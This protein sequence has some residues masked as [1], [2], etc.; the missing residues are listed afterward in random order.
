MTRLQSIEA[1]LIAINETV[2]QEL[3]DAYLTLRNKNYL[4]FAR[5]GSQAGK[6]KTTKGTPD[7]FF[8][9]PNGRY[10]FVEYSTNITAGVE[11]LADDIKKCIDP[12]KTGVPI[13]EIEEI[14]IC[15]NF[16]LKSDEIASLRAIL[17]RTSIIL[18]ICTLDELAIELHL[19]HR[20]LVH[21]YLGLPLDTGQIISLDNF[22]KE[23]ER[24]AHG[25]A[26]PI[27]NTFVHRQDELANLKSLIDNHDFIIVTGSAGV[28]KTKLC[29][30]TI[31]QYLKENTSFHAF[32]ISDKGHLLLDDLYTYLSEDQDCILF[33]DDANRIDRFN[34]ITGFY[35]GS[36]K[37]KLKIIVTVRDYA[38]ERIE[39]LCQGFR[40]ASIPVMKLTDEQIRD[41]IKA[42]PFKI[43]NPDYQKEIIRIADGNPRL[44]IMASLL[45]RK[46]EKLEALNDVGE[47]FDLY[48]STFVQDKGEFSNKLN[49]KVLGLIAFFYAVPFKDQEF[50]EPVLKSF[51]ITYSQFIDTIDELEKLEL[52]DIQFEHVKISEQNLATFFFYKAFISD[53][54]LAFDTLL[55]TQFSTN[56][57]RFE[58]TVIPANNNFGYEKVMQ[59]L[60]P[61]LQK[62]LYSINNDHKSTFQFLQSFWFYLQDETLEYI[63]N[64]IAKLPDD[65]STE[66]LYNPDQ[67]NLY[68]ENDEVIELLSEF[69][70]FPTNKLKDA[71]ELCFEYVRKNKRIFQNL[72]QKIKESLKFDYK[73]EQSSY[74]RQDSLYDLLI[75]HLK[76][77]DQIYVRSFFELSKSFL[78]F[79][80]QHTKAARGHSISIYQYPLKND[81]GIK[82]FRAR[83][84]TTLDEQFQKYYDASF[85]LLVSYGKRSPDVIDELM[86][87][88][89]ILLIP[90][91]SQHLSPENFD[92]CVYVQSQI[93]WFR[94]HGLDNAKFDEILVRFRNKEYETYLK[95]DWDRYRDKEMFEFDD[96]KQYD[97]LKEAEVRGNFKFATEDDIKNFYE[98]FLKIKNKAN[99][100]W[101]YTNVLD[102]IIDETF[103]SDFVLGVK[104]LEVI[105]KTGNVIN[106]VPFRLFFN[107]VKTGEQLSQIVQLIN[108]HNFDAKW[109]WELSLYNT[110]D[111]N[112]LHHVKEE[113]IISTIDGITGYTTLD[114]N[115]LSK[116]LPLYPYLIS[117]IWALIYKKNQAET[118][119]I[120]IWDDV[121]ERDLNAWSISDQ[122][123]EDMYIQQFN[124]EEHYDFDSQSL[125]KLVIKNPQ[126][127]KTYINE[128][129][130]KLRR[131]SA[132]DHLRLGFIWS[133]NNIEP[134]IEELF[135][136]VIDDDN[137]GM[138]NHF[139][140]SFFNGIDNDVQLKANKFLIDYLVKNSTDAQRVDMVVNI[141]RNSQKELF[142][143][144]LL[145]FLE[146]NPDLEVFKSVWWRGNGGVYSGEVNMGDEEAAD[147]KRI[148]NTVEK[149]S[150]GIKL[151]PIKKYLNDMIDASIK[152]GD[153]ERKR[154]FLG[155]D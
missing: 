136:T 70:R 63:Y 114:L 149:S 97:K 89:V 105:I 77:D 79:K 137:F 30:E 103:H 72:V 22:V 9:L 59:K 21:Q 151:I 144:I 61:H 124:E 147:W 16:K 43:L 10:L 39:L 51:D 127:I 31:N 2:F 143:D 78:Q 71:L 84:W 109:Q 15:I 150:S 52:V 5:S 104:F 35:R 28:G 88:D 85:Q 117:K 75:K 14:I 95:L 119:K 32:C 154:K 120:K 129:F 107:H 53:D 146:V 20:D 101:N 57:K 138:S 145:K 92:H 102:M 100:P 80:F 155:Y 122:M 99:N 125:K 126:F 135:E 7:T 17:N 108:G 86:A 24:A 55:A 140:N 37:G 42:E 93:L 50:I 44:A 153:W 6:Q 4:A 67:N 34:Q 131:T 47:L 23:Y 12:K 69:W 76:D 81:V 36:R 141:A 66:Y 112:L 98:L 91:I 96:F 41:V 68:N 110:L 38:L 1:A 94:K 25:I 58:D 54:L 116:F 142:D 3:C 13:K 49:I 111:N 29:I 87:E 65:T 139:A 8:V 40:P 19:H 27:S 60:Q 134:I 148:L 74:F 18:T 64:F 90:I 33:V 132:A 11:K 83:L 123:A 115:Q 133:I 56:A 121:F 106:Y 82:A 73:D 130:Q 46:K 113:T 128:T 26:T 152:S 45:A 62:Y 118:G 48:F